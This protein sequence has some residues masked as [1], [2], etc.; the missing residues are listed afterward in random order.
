[1]V[2]PISSDFIPHDQTVDG[3]P[4][5]IFKIVLP[6]GSP[7]QLVYTG[8][9]GDRN[10][11]AND[12]VPMDDVGLGI[13]KVIEE[14]KVKHPKVY[15]HIIILGDYKYKHGLN[16]P[17]HW[18]RDT[19]D[20]FN[21]YFQSDT[22]ISVINGNH[23][24]GACGRHAKSF[25]GMLEDSENGPRAIKAFHEANPTMKDI[26]RMPARFYADFI[27]HRNDAGKET[28]YMVVLYTDT[29]V[30]Q[31]DEAQIAWINQ[32]DTWIAKNAPGLKYKI[33]PGHQ[34]PT[35]TFGKRCLSTEGKHKYQVKPESL[36]NDGN[37]H[38]FTT[39]GLT[40]AGVRINEWT[41]Y[42]AHEH[43][44]MFIY[45]DVQYQPLATLYPEITDIE[46]DGGARQNK[47]SGHKTVMPGMLDNI[48]E[49]GF[50]T[51]VFNPNGSRR[52]R[53]YKVPVCKSRQ[54][55]LAKKIEIK[56]EYYLDA[57]G[58]I[59]VYKLDASKKKMKIDLQK[60]VEADMRVPRLPKRY[61][62]RQKKWYDQIFSA[63]KT[64]SLY[65]VAL[66]MSRELLACTNDMSAADKE[67]MQRKVRDREAQVTMAITRVKE[68]RVE[69]YTAEDVRELQ[70]AI[71]KIIYVY[72]EADN[73]IPCTVF[74]DRL[75]F[76]RLL[77]SQARQRFEVT[78][79]IYD[80]QEEKTMPKPNLL[81]MVTLAKKALE[82]RVD[83]TYDN[84]KSIQKSDIGDEDDGSYATKEEADIE[85]PE[86]PSDMDFSKEEDYKSEEVNDVELSAAS[87]GQASVSTIWETTAPAAL[88]E[89][90]VGNF[91][92]AALLG[93]L[94]E[95]FDDACREIYRDALADY[96]KDCLGD[97]YLEALHE[98]VGKSGFRHA[99]F[100][101][102]ASVIMA[103]QSLQT[104][105]FP[106]ELILGFLKAGGANMARCK[107]YV[108]NAMMQHAQAKLISAD[109]ASEWQAYCILRVK[110]LK[111]KLFR[112]K[113][114]DQALENKYYERALRDICSNLIEDE[115][116]N[117]NPAYA[118]MF[119]QAFL[120]A[121]IKPATLNCY[122]KQTGQE[123][124]YLF[125]QVGF[126]IQQLKVAHE[127]ADRRPPGMLAC[128]KPA[129][130]T[131]AL[132]DRVL[133][134]QK[135][136]DLLS[137][138]K[139]YEEPEALIATLQQNSLIADNVEISLDE[140]HRYVVKVIQ[141]A[142]ENDPFLLAFA[143][144]VETLLNL[145]YRGLVE[146]ID[147]HLLKLQATLHLRKKSPGSERSHE[148]VNRIVSERLLPQKQD[149][150]NV[151]I[152]GL[153][154]TVRTAIQENTFVGSIMADALQNVVISLGD[155]EHGREM[156]SHRL[157][158]TEGEDQLD[159]VEL[160][161]APAGRAQP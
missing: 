88:L 106:Y 132:H 70:I 84:A 142:A 72:L 60:T 104:T 62:E 30:L 6:K 17:K 135:L 7:V 78:Q 139:A 19:G 42:A 9:N 115:I 3:L 90:G 125:A 55:A 77:V 146:E 64:G 134:M 81:A 111:G 27:F 31:D 110:F 123:T 2:A 46:G 117:A 113:T 50:G 122:F 71:E 158:V 4:S 105:K 91:T 89:P 131:L 93:R 15:N 152:M 143:N 37:F 76:M 12:W 35:S 92:S 36:G 45:S 65:T 128:F 10:S 8:C 101:K 127:H 149:K 148:Q 73:F 49:F 41:F 57:S 68:K 1:M 79:A 112:G 126:A 53:H 140:N 94:K 87:A 44:A 5:G 69:D 137:P 48:S 61:I 28:L 156:R 121:M 47:H 97:A 129:P 11:N 155:G 160:I 114:M 25:E 67:R 120:R 96:L 80:R 34:T 154:Q 66:L 58:H 54:D 56:S 130:L 16:K 151:T 43:E 159:D 75:S 21:P 39:L 124:D 133:L 99:N 85:T 138:A 13:Y 147:P 100:H 29:S 98:P 95:T 107:S 52:K 144:L 26:L 59:V 40:R 141:V 153:L 83:T 32:I 23:E 38:Q 82:S 51:M 63:M 14:T 74:Y 33:M 136:F 161:S 102:V 20:Y 24:A 103:L 108:R 116:K 18:V 118:W 150:Q 109:G 119:D 86:L 145:D 22:P 157:S